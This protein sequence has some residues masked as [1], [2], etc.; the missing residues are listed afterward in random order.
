MALAAALIWEVRTTGAD[1]AG[2]AFKPGASGTD[3][4]QQS[5]AQYALTGLTTAAADAIL[6][7][8]SSAADMVGNVIQITS[9]TNF[10]VG[11]YEIVSVVVGVSITVDRTCTTAAGAAGVGNVGG[12]LL[13]PGM[14]AGARVAGNT[15]FIKYN[16]SA[17]ILS[18]ATP[19]ISGGPVNDT[20]DGSDSVP[21]FWIGYDSTRTTVNTDS[22]K[23]LIQVPAAGVTTISVFKVNPSSTLCNTIVRN[24]KIDGQSKTSIRG[25]ESSGGAANVVFENCEAINCTNNGFS[26]SSAVGGA[27]NSLAT[28]CSSSA[29]F[30]VSL[31]RSYAIGCVA[32]SNTATGF[33]ISSGY[34]LNCISAS[35]TGGSTD[36]FSQGGGLVNARLYNCVAY[37]NGRDGFRMAS[38]N[39]RG[40]TAFNTIA[41]GNGG[42]G[43]NG[44]GFYQQSFCAG[45]SNTSGNETGVDRSLSF[46]TLTADPFTNAAAG[47]FSL[48]NT[49]GGGALCRA[50]G[51]PGVFPG[52]LTTGYL[53]IGAVQHEDAGGGG[54]PLING[55]LVA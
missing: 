22:N 24:I 34:C 36:G 9:G 33:E 8:A 17:Y 52:G 14:V 37:A 27:V 2:G 42:Y 5:A 49:A 50:A 45:G 1:T 40:S 35:N 39:P 26:L 12:A 21:D 43:F 23:P 18:T 46:V 6:L 31:D 20:V 29:A 28:G 32:R 4:S 47:D 25:F 44:N 55:R 7:H 15:V 3:F 53:D 38:G 41:Y 16:A 13:T 19:N 30:G 48:N 51:F 54:G 10:T 11:F